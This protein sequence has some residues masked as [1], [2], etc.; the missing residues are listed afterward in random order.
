MRSKTRTTVIHQVDFPV[1]LA[2]D[3][4]DERSA[5]HEAAAGST[6]CLPGIGFASIH[7]ARAALFHLIFADV[8]VGAV[9]HTGVR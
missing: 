3:N 5:V 4:G 1:A 8:T 9:S 2:P 7:G 6:V